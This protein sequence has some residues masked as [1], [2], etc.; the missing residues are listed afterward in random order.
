FVDRV[1]VKGRDLPTDLYE[2][3]DG[4]DAAERDRKLDLRDRLADAIREFQRGDLRA[5]R[6]AFES[7]ARADPTDAT[8]ASYLARIAGREH[9]GVPATWDGVTRMLQK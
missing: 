2:V 4:L 6:V 8:Y 7:L 9:E 5:A 3:L 1:M